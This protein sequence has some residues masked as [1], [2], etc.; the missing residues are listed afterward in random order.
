MRKIKSA[1][2]NLCLMANRQKKAISNRNKIPFI[3]YQSY[4]D[5][6]KKKTILNNIKDI[7]T[8]IIGDCKI[9]SIEETLSINTFII[10]VFENITKKD[11]LKKLSE[12]LYFFIVKYII[13]LIVHCTILHDIDDKYSFTIKYIESVAHITM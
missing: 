3:N 5:Y 9:S 6:S 10:Y 8:D 7:T 4:N 12:Y 2:S 11:K 13:T 1:P